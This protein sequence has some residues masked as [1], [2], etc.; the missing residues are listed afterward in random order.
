MLNQSI[1][2]FYLT[3]SLQHNFLEK[4]TLKNQLNFDKENLLFSNQNT[5]PVLKKFQQT[6]YKVRNNSEFF[7]CFFVLG[8]GYF[9]GNFSE[10]YYEKEKKT[11]GSHVHSIH[12]NE[13]E[14][15]RVINQK[16]V[17]CVWTRFF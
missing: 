10:K 2:L 4:K 8:K 14:R 5:I 17:W 15:E 16:C 6:T 3:L 12:Q 7:S 13:R 11:F 9:P 1:N